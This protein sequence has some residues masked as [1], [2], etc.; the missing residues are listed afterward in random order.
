MLAF[1]G[2]HRRELRT[3]NPLETT[4]KEVKRR[5]RVAIL[6]PNDASLLRLVSAVLIEISDDWETRRIHLAMTED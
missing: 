3:A 5:T 1:P 2:N 6:F 4:N